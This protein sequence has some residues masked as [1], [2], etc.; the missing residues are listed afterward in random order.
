[1]CPLFLINV[2]PFHPFPPCI[3]C[4][5]LAQAKFK[6]E[7]CHITTNKRQNLLTNGTGQKNSP[8]F[9]NTLRAE[10]SGARG[11]GHGRSFTS[12]GR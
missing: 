1:M 5:G 11:G 4:R 7:I 8:A 10:C 3:P 6:R 9:S 12:A 2:F